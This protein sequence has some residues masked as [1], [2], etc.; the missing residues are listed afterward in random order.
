VTAEQLM[1]ALRALIDKGQ[2]TTARIARA[3]LRAAYQQAMRA[4]FD[5]SVP[6]ELRGFDVRANPLDLIPAAA[7]AGFRRA[8]ERALSW[9][10]LVAYRK[11]VEKLPGGALKDALLLG[12]LLGGQRVVQLSRVTHADVDLHGR[13]IS[14]RDPKGRRL[15]PRLHTLPLEGRAF[16]LVKR[17]MEAPVWRRKPKT[18]AERQLVLDLEGTDTTTPAANRP[19]LSRRDRV[20]VDDVILSKTVSEIAAAMVAASE[21]RAPFRGGD[22]RRT[23]ET[24]LAGMRVPRDVRAHL[25]SHGVSGVQAQHYDRHDYMAEMREALEAWEARLYAEN[26]VSLG[27]RRIEP[28][29][30]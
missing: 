10:E 8:G 23:A 9:P 28:A 26:V 20:P 12:L 1:P 19:L 7:F 3:S 11:R 6:A 17:R 15:H 30:A 16:E 25:L 2:G 14:L 24:L 18:K 21:A 4:P 29:Q 22:I 5:P 13:T 27:E